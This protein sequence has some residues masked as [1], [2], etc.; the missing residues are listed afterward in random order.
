M[1]SKAVLESCTSVLKEKNALEEWAEWLTVDEEE[2]GRGSANSLQGPSLHQTESNTGGTESFDKGARL[3][4]TSTTLN[5]DAK[6]YYWIALVDY[7]EDANKQ[8]KP[9]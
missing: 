3:K 5:L 9:T 4:E 6:E 1:A 7:H 2:T 8:P